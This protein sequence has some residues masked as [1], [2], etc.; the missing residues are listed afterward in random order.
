[1]SG[2]PDIFLPSKSDQIFICVPHMLDDSSG[3]TGGKGND[4]L[5]TLSLPMYKKAD[6]ETVFEEK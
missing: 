3:E 1:M 6:G 5:S 4:M 2:S